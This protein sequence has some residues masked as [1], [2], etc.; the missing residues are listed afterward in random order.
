MSLLSLIS[1]SAC[2]Q[3]V[4]QQPTATTKTQE[5]K[6]VKMQK[7]PKKST[8]A[9]Q[10][11]EEVKE[12]KIRLSSAATLSDQLLDVETGNNQELKVFV[13][14]AMSQIAPANSG[15]PVRYT[16]YLEH[17]L[18][19]DKKVYVTNWTPVAT[20]FSASTIKIFI[21]INIYQQFKT[22]QLS[23]EEFYTLVEKDVVQ[24]A[25]D[26]LH[27]PIGTTYSLEELCR[28]MMEKSDNIATNV[29]IDYAGGF[30]AVN[31]T[32][33]QTVGENHHS[34]LERKM[35]DIR[36]IENGKAN[37]I[38]AK[39][40]SQVMLKLYQGAVLDPETDQQ[41]LNL[42][43]HT[44]NR[45]KLP[46][47]LPKEAIIY[48]KTGEAA[49][50]GIEN[51]VALIDYQGEVFV[52]CVL[53]EMNGPGEVPETSTEEQANSQVKAIAELGSRVTEWMLMTK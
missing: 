28:L 3:A 16:V 46:A 50:R 30:D 36:N 1:L 4:K 21:L 33:A 29:L 34:K 11:V 43:S 53:T 6:K 39:E 52:M 5:T 42:M 19:K 40:V 2:N 18:D 37:Q 26:M 23:P 41:L 8:L 10:K 49:Y 35:M 15:Q 44:K 51:D 12:E 47:N 24:G 22:G 27:D 38:N 17:L 25:G 31:Q 20:Q 48:N 9:S 32:I 45:T 13:R 14:E 7:V